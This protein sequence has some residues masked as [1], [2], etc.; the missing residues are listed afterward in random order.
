MCVSSRITRPVGIKGSG[1]KR[2]C[3]ECATD[4]F[5]AL[6]YIQILTSNQIDHIKFRKLNIY[7]YILY[8]SVCMCVCQIQSPAQSQKKYGL[9]ITSNDV[10]TTTTKKHNATDGDEKEDKKMLKT[11]N[12]NTV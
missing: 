6:A 9:R 3:N 2:Q 8:L 10:Q 4:K 12:S 11:N 7:W 1:Y 5:D